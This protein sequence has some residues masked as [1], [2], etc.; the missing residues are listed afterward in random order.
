MKTVSA[1]IL[2]FSFLT[3]SIA[4]RNCYLD[5]GFSAAYPSTLAN[6]KYNQASGNTKGLISLSLFT[7]SMYAIDQHHAIKFG[8]QINYTKIKLQEA[9]EV[10]FTAGNGDVTGKG[11]TNNLSILNLGMPIVYSYTKNSKVRYKAG[12]IPHLRLNL[13]SKLTNTSNDKEITFPNY[14][15][16]LKKANLAA[17]IGVGFLQKLGAQLELEIT[18]Y[19]QIN[20]FRDYDST[21]GNH[22]FCEI[23]VAFG[24][25]RSKV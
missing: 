2:F 24:F 5:F 22:H 7:N 17:Y 19:G 12:F 13:S 1:I 20:I 9:R 14:N 18:P 25:I 4:Q 15:Y 10:F 8:T 21:F 16:T 11:I 6:F 3:F 23:G